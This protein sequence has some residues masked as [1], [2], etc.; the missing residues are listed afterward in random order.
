MSISNILTPMNIST[1]ARRTQ[2][3]KPVGHVGQQEVHRAQAADGE[4]LESG[5]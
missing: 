2:E 4:E 5:R 1:T 3:G